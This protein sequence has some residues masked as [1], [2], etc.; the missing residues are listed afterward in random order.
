LNVDI[1]R[2]KTDPSQKTGVG[3]ALV[4]PNDR[5]ILT[6]LGT[7]DGLTPADFGGDLLT[8][9]RHWHVAGYFLMQSLRRFWPEWLRRLKQHGVTLSLDTNWSPD[10]RWEDVKELLPLVDVFLPNDAEAMAIT[11]KANVFDAGRSLASHG[12]LTV[13]TCGRNGVVAFRGD[14]L[15]RAELADPKTINVVDTTGAGDCFDAGF[16]RA[17]QLGWSIEKCL[18]IGMRCGRANVQAAGGFAGQLCETLA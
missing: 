1:S 14:D 13:V 8:I 6:Y 4:E 15:W 11:G 12:C 2:V 5:A 16:V 10:G 18:E 3:F 9:S 7:I 17:W